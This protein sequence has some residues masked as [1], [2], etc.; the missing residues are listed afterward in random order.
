MLSGGKNGIDL[1]FALSLWTVFLAKLVCAMPECVAAEQPGAFSYET[2]R[3]RART[4]AASEY[5]PE[6]KPELPDGL[7]KLS[8]D[9]YQSI[10]FVPSEGPW[11]NERLRFT[12]QAFHRGFIYQEPVQIHLVE[13]GQVRDFQF[14][15]KE[16]N[17]G[18]LPVPGQLPPNL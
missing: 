4:L 8:Y 18:K 3:G 17:Y 11:Q 9:D 6:T 5:R 13:E 14:S 10:K 1:L 16:F 7:K 12:F 2:L 15:P